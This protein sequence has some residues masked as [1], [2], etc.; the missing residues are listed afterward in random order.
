M[1]GRWSREEFDAWFSSEL[2]KTVGS[3]SAVIDLY[4]RAVNEL[5]SVAD[6]RDVQR[7]HR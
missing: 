4:R 2:D 5:L 3:T 1:T 6:E 7:R